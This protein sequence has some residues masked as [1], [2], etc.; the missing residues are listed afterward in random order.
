MLAFFKGRK[1]R[2]EILRVRY[3]LV[4][5]CDTHSVKFKDLYFK[6]NIF[7]RS[8]SFDLCRIYSLLIGCHL[9]VCVRVYLITCGIEYSIEEGPGNKVLS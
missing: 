4:F 6:H 7:L 1:T 8:Y 2:S 9:G 5:C 3:F